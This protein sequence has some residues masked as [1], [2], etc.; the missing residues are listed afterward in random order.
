MLNIF[1]A[2]IAASVFSVYLLFYLRG[3]S[4]TYR[5][6]PLYD[7]GNEALAE[8]FEHRVLNPLTYTIIVGFGVLAII[9]FF[10]GWSM[11]WRLKSYFPEFYE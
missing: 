10:V 4:D 6:V 5:M 1:M 7:K 2:I 11:L 3:C 8:Q 9:F